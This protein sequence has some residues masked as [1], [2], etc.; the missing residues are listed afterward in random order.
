MGKFT[1]SPITS[2]YRSYQKFNQNLE[3]IETAIQDTLSRSGSTPNQMEATLDMN[4]NR[5]INLPAPEDP[6]DAARL[7][8]VLDYAGSSGGGG[9]GGSVP[10]T[11]VTGK[12]TAFTPVTE[13]VQDIV[14]SMVVAGTDITTSYDDVTGQLTIN[15]TASG[16]GGSVPWTSVTGKPTAFTPVTEDVQDIVGAM[17][18]AGTNVTTSYDDVTGQLTI[19]STAGFKTL[20]DYGAVEDG[21]TDD[22]AAIDAALADTT[23]KR[24]YVEG[25]VATSSPITDFNKFFYGPGR[26]IL[27]AASNKKLPGRFTDIVSLP[28]Q[29]TGSDLNYYFSSDNSKITAEYYRLGQPSGTNFRQNL[30]Q[31]IGGT[32]PYY[33]SS[34]TPY[35]QVFQNYVGWSGVNARTT[36][37]I[38]SGSTTSVTLNNASHGIS[39][40]DTVGFVY[41]DG[42]ITETK[43]V[44][45]SGATISWTGALT[46]TYPSNTVVTKGYR[47]MN[48]LYYNQVN[49][50]GG[51]DAYANLARITVDYV[52]LASQTH[53]YETATGGLYGGDMTMSQSGV[54]GTG[55]EI[56]IRD[57]GNDV[58]AIGEVYTYNRT[59]NTG[60]KAVGWMGTLHKSE[61]TQPINVF[62]T[63]LG[64]GD[65]GYDASQGN[66][67]TNQA[68]FQMASD[69]RFYFNATVDNA[70]T[71]KMGSST[72]SA[73][74]G[75]AVGTSYMHHKENG[76][77][78]SRGKRIEFVVNG[79]TS[80]AGYGSFN[81]RAS[82]LEAHRDFVGYRADGTTS[83]NISGADGKIYFYD[84]TGADFGVQIARV[85][86]DLTLQGKTNIN[87]QN[88]SGVS[89]GQMTGSGLYKGLQ[90]ANNN[91]ISVKQNQFIYLDGTSSITGIY[92]DGTNIRLYKA[93]ANVASW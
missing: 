2:G 3:D 92:Y 18:V 29:G 72:Y 77:L 22:K 76:G 48:P 66:F 42:N 56:Q 24:V 82:V 89:F 39:T 84:S 11:S 20:K 44:T 36:G 17:V 16:G 69:H 13:N 71:A 87:F 85:S 59:N 74:Y 90:M 51:G 60:G 75:N 31:S 83:Y 54:Y 43:V 53:F 23:T 10:W 47:T 1:R 6:S 32:F 33:E 28:S 79:N 14:G 38:T 50:A 4:S 40:G 9:G 81:V 49:H 15:S 63:I 65:V 30:V 80:A 34:T 64:K 25:V 67:G 61:G 55:I 7:Q 8:D 68:A 37:I 46:Q 86:D 26:F 62:H 45:V 52:P 70:L 27:T 93:G 5:I 88:G 12:P 57:Q 58:A 21:V 41:T 78:D 19:N 91:N 73:L 35:F